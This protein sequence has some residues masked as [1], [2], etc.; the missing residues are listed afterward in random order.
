MHILRATDYRVMPW[1]NGGGTTTEIAVSPEGAALDD[2]DWRVSMARVER[3]GPFSAFPGIDRTLSILEGEGMILNVSDR[4]PFELTKASEPLPFPADVPTRANL[5]AGPIVALNVM[6]RR[7][8]MVHSVERMTI[9]GTVELAIA[10]ET[11]L[12][13]CHRG[14]VRADGPEAVVLDA[15]DALRIDR[16]SPVLRLSADDRATVFVILINAA[17]GND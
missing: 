16:G 14:R 4:I 1:K 8:R 6:S 17:S 15:L 7:A 5:I 11:M 2:F 3:D 13:F 10:A 12:V 9:A